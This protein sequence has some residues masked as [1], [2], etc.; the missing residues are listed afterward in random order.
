MARLPVF[1]Q[2][3]VALDVGPWFGSQRQSLGRLYRRGVRWLPV[4]QAVQHVQDMGIRRGRG[5]SGRFFST[6]LS[7]LHM[8]SFEP[9]ASPFFEFDSLS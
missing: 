3:V 4:D 9:N 2:G 1:A 7:S 6:R 5:S 8:L